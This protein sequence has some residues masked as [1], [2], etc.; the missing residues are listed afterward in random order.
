[1][2][3]P[4]KIVLVDDHALIRQ[5]IRNYLELDPNLIVVGET[6]NGQ[7][8]I[9]MA[10]QH[11]PDIM[12][13]DVI[14]PG[15]NGVEVTKG[16]REVS[17][18]SQ[19]IILTSFHEDSYVLPALRAG[20]QSYVL[21]DI[22][23]PALKD[24]VYR[25]LNGE[26]VLDPLVVNR[27]VKAIHTRKLDTIDPFAELTE[28]EVEILQ[29]IAFGCANTD[30]AEKL[31]ISEKT[32]KSHVSNIL[33]KLQKTDRTQLAAMAWQEGLVSTQKQAYS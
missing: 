23:L 21:K 32:V 1:M 7:D 26:K 18:A 3:K 17:P 5:G 14:M 10:A 30:I 15:M 19:I 28:R 12:M 9:L 16:V 4:V 27:V 6:D 25:T 22:N 2:S 8:A 13:V 24:T 11:Q 20:A 29:L 33:S 31:I